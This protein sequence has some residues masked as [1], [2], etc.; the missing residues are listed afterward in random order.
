MFEIL[1]TFKQTHNLNN[2]SLFGVPFLTDPQLNFYSLFLCTS[3]LAHTHARFKPH[4]NDNS[5]TIIAQKFSITV[6]TECTFVHA[7][8][9]TYT[10]YTILVAWSEAPSISLFTILL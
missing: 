1:H 2:H 8:Y 5:F 7:F 4:Q 6:F 3:S 10:T 9:S